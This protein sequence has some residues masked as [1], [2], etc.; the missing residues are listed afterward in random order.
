MKQFRIIATCD[1]EYD[2]GDKAHFENTTIGIPEEYRK[3][4]TDLE[5]ALKDIQ[6]IKREGRGRDAKITLSDVRVQS[7]IITDWEDEH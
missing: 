5:T 1:I 6:K 7:R 4:Y 2:F 3:T